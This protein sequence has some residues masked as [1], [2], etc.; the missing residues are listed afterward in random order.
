MMFQMNMSF[1]FSPHWKYILYISRHL[2]ICDAFLFI[3]NASSMVFCQSLSLDLY[4]YAFQPGADRSIWPLLQ[5]KT[6]LAL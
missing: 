3:R 2:F 6:H 4:L 5:H 1:L